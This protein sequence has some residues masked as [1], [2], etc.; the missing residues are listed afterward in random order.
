MHRY[1]WV[2]FDLARPLLDKQ[3]CACLSDGLP[4]NAIGEQEKSQAMEHEYSKNM[5]DM[6]FGQGSQRA[7]RIL[8]DSNSTIN[9]II[10]TVLLKIDDQY[11]RFSVGF[12]GLWS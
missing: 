3:H 9:D 2:P 1:R 8:L 7:N 11:L 6:N 12:F 4:E 10:R 5:G